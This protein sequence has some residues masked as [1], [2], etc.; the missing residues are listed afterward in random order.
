LVLVVTVENMSTLKILLLALHN[1]SIPINRVVM[2]KILFLARLPLSEG[3][4]E[5]ILIPPQNQAEME[6]QEEERLKIISELLMRLVVLAQQDRV[7]MAVPQHIIQRVA[8]VA[9]V[10]EQRRL[11]LEEA[12]Q[13]KQDTVVMDLHHP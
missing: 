11:A 8:E 3:V 12:E 6:V 1:Q 9:E 10:V 13:Q 5:E 2:E 7:M 4:G